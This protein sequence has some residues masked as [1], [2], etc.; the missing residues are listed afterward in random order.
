[1]SMDK[2][3][4]KQVTTKHFKCQREDSTKLLDSVRFIQDPLEAQWLEKFNALKNS[5]EKHGHTKVTQSL[6]KK[7]AFQAKTQR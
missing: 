2:Q 4:V 5:K 7:L 3:L 6:N 1:M